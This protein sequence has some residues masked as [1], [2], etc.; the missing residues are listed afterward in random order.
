M[1]A[2]E[3]PPWPSDSDEDPTLTTMR[4]AS[5]S[6]VRSVT[7]CGVD[8]LDVDTTRHSIRRG[9]HIRSITKPGVLGPD[10]RGLRHGLSCVQPGLGVFLHGWDAVGTQAGRLGRVVRKDVRR[11]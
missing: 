5:R 9:N 2:T 1:A 4:R 7:G 8:R 3:T 11:R 6:L 10:L